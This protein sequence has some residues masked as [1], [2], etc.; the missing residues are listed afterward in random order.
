MGKPLYTMGVIIMKPEFWAG[1]TGVILSVIVWYVS[2]NFPVFEVQSAGPALFPRLV[3]LIIC[4][5]AL[6]LIFQSLKRA[7]DKNTKISRENL[8]Q[9]LA[10]L[11]TLVLYY[12]AIDL[13]GYFVSTFLFS[14]VIILIVQ[15]SYGKK[16]FGFILLNST[17]ICTGIFLVFR[18]LLKISLPSGI[19]F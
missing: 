17:L 11:I 6:V 18:I 15:K 19:L 16:T 2:G 12:F 1:L 9:L 10:V 7:E 13:V 8:S 14:G 3:A 5:L 4:L